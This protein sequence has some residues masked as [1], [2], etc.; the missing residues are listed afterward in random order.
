[1]TIVTHLITSLRRLPPII[2]IGGLIFA[3]L[4]I[5][6][7]PSYFYRALIVLSPPLIG[8][9]GIGLLL[10][11]DAFDDEKALFSGI[12]S[13]SLT[14]TAVFLL[15]HFA[16]L[17]FGNGL[18]GFRGI[19]TTLF[20]MIFGVTLPAYIGGMIA[21]VLLPE[22]W[23]IQSGGIGLG[24]AVMAIMLGAL[25]HFSPFTGLIF[26]LPPLVTV[27]AIA[28]TF[29]RNPAKESAQLLRGGLIAG[30]LTGIIVCAAFSI[31][32]R[33]ILCF[34]APTCADQLGIAG[35]LFLYGIAVANL[36]VIT[37]VHWLVGSLTV[38]ALHRFSPRD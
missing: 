11:E 36:A 17:L 29:R 22:R 35:L 31:T 7:L 13:L 3:F 20:G 15:V 5:L 27:S 6:L 16:L 28:W 19:L 34:G 4:L 24:V 33:L 26:L 2:L 12:L 18:F 1:M 32:V 8:F 38:F 9:V 23:T 10:E 25:T 14:I 30:A 37:V 21:Y